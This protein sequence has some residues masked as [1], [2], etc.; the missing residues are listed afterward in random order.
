VRQMQDRVL[1]Q[2]VCHER[3]QGPGLCTDC[4]RVQGV[5]RECLCPVACPTTFPSSLACRPHLWHQLAEAPISRA[6]RG[7]NSSALSM[8]PSSLAAYIPT[9]TAVVVAEMRAICGAGVGGGRGGWRH[10]SCFWC[11][12]GERQRSGGLWG[13][14]GTHTQYR[15]LSSPISASVI[16]SLHPMCPSFI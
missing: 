16:H 5:G 15:Q 12:G 1:G 6:G 14:T 3:E 13:L 10:M 2:Q 11:F 4:N 7:V 8:P 9:G